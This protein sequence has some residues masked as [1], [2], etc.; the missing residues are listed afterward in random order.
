MQVSPPRP[1]IASTA[2]EALDVVFE[3]MIE[4]PARSK[5]RFMTRRAV[6]GEMRR[7]YWGAG[8][9]SRLHER[10]TLRSKA[11]AAKCDFVIGN[12]EAIQLAQSYSFGIASQSA[13]ASQVK[14]WGWTVAELRRHGG[15]ATTR[16]GSVISVAGDVDIQVLYAA[17]EEATGLVSLDEA[18]S[19]FAEV[20]ITAVALE[21][22]DDVAGRAAGL[23]GI[24]Q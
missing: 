19:V 3:H 4:D 18:R 6:Y 16:D 5:F 20:G 11:Y 10:C 24:N 1:L 12:D 21:D 23:L 9:R 2:E 14:A 15:E 17:P 7:A 8:L 13:L 22:A